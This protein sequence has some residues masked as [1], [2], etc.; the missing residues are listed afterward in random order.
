LAPSNLDVVLKPPAENAVA[1]DGGSAAAEIVAITVDTYTDLKSAQA[2]L[3]R[4]ASKAGIEMEELLEGMEN[5]ERGL[6]KKPSQSDISATR[7]N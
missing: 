7:R 3:L 4:Y 1:D 5:S 6:L 2:T